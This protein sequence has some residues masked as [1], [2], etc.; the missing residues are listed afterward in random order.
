MPVITGNVKLPI[1]P[2]TYSTSNQFF[3]KIQRES[4]CEPFFARSNEQNELKSILKRKRVFQWKFLNIFFLISKSIV[5]KNRI[6]LD[7]VIRGLFICE[8]LIHISKI[9]LKCQISNQNVSFYLRIQYSR[10]K[11]AGRVYRE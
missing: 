6:Q 2:A 5:E 9:G 10:S 8:S 11:T 4:T 1:L 3:I 7:L